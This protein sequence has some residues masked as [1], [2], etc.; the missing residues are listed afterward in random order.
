[1]LHKIGEITTYFYCE[2]KVAYDITIWHLLKRVN[3]FI[4]V[5]RLTTQKVKIK[6]VLTKNK[7]LAILAFC[8]FDTVRMYRTNVLVALAAHFLGLPSIFLRYM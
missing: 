7:S 8:S 4:S 2:R 1:M 3:V 5:L 6:K